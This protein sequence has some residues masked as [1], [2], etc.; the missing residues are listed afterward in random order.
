MQDIFK[1]NKWCSSPEAYW[2]LQ[3]EYKRD[4]AN[5]KYRFSYKVWLKLS[6]GWYYNALKMPIYLNK[7]NVATIQVKYYNSN[8][9]G[10]TYSGTTDW[11]TIENKV[12][13]TTPFYAQLVDTGGYAQANWDVVGTSDT[14]N[15]SVAPAYAT[16]YQS[17]Y[18]TG[19]NYLKISWGADVECDYLQYSIDGGKTFKDVSG[20]PTYIIENLIP[21]TKYNIITRVRR[22][23]S[24]LWS[25]TE[26]LEAT[27]LSS[28]YISAMS[29]FNIGTSFS[30]TI[31]NPK[32][33]Y[34]K[35]YINAN[36]VSDVIER[37]TK[38]NGT[39]T[40]V[41]TEEE[42]ND[43][44]KTIP[45]SKNGKYKIL[46]IC[47]DLGSSND[48]ND[49]VG[50][51]TYYAVE[52]DCRPSVS[53]TAE[54]TNSLSLALTGNKNKII[55]YVSNVLVK[56]TSNGNK[57]ASISSNKLSCKDGQ[58][59]TGNSAT[60]N[61]IENNV[62]TGIATDTRGYSNSDIK[63][64]ALIDYIKLTLNINV[65]R[66]APTTGEIA[67][68]FNGN[69][70]NGNFG[71]EVNTLSLKYRY[72]D[73]EENSIYCDWIELNPVIKNNTYSNGDL[74]ITLGS[75][76]DYMKTYDFEFVAND[77]IYTDYSISVSKSVRSGKS[78]FD[79]G[80]DDFN[81]N[82]KLNLYETS[83]IRHIANILYPVNSIY[84]SLTQ[85]I[86]EWLAGEWEFLN[87][88]VYNNTTYYVYKRTNENEKIYFEDVILLYDNEEIYVE[89]TLLKGS[90]LL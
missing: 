6:G 87:T 62:F 17:L 36:D 23:D 84:M 82:G 3:Y 10:W 22:T 25:Q 68:K 20:Y 61:K 38:I 50:S 86:P 81:I 26:S 41:L 74:S 1:D 28:P 51:K 52:N 18:E 43:L 79:W 9:K 4:G 89:N 67:L 13:G 46:V 19:D 37:T 63:T 66:P 57:S 33:R 48:S 56:I 40:F 60:F 12:S 71:K 88:I 16:P 59:A 11:F 54:D 55:K 83:I 78:V 90:D 72:K 35:L 32:E 76:F 45:R 14:Y 30:C 53:I 7:N 44:Y 70:F 39:Y 15:L 2:T 49:V 42:N 27:T 34:L 65:Y 31:Y 69:F 58:S 24:Q 8:E 80:K 73:S 47:D 85:E 77:K 75:N 5:M 64:L 21:N 29:D